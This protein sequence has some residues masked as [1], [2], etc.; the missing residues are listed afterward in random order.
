M[1][2]QLVEIIRAAAPFGA[3]FALAMFALSLWAWVYVQRYRARTEILKNADTAVLPQLLR[4]EVE[5]LRIHAEGL[6]KAQRHE[7]VMTVL[8]QR[9]AGSRRRFVLSLMVA[10]FVLVLSLAGIVTAKPLETAKPPEASSECSEEYLALHVEKDGWVN[11]LGGN[12]SPRLFEYTLGNP[13]QACTALVT[14]IYMDV[15]DVRPYQVGPPEG[16]TLK[17]NLDVKLSPEMKGR[18]ITVSSTQRNYPPHSAPEII[19]VNVHTAAEGVYYVLR[20][21]V[22]WR[23]LK[24]KREFVTRA[25]VSIAFF[26]AENSMLAGTKSSTEYFKEQKELV[27]QARAA[28]GN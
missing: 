25:P 8:A 18:R 7:H 6:T 27:K 17:Y 22:A 28:Y 2:P 4:D 1:P 10:S 24:T 21:V 23:D 13:T 26:Q 14:G 15:L 5:M 9:E 3:G 12:N 11:F 16:E 20:F 19:A